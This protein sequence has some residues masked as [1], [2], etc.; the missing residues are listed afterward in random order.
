M[1][2][3]RV[4]A[5]IPLVLVV[6]FLVMSLTVFL[7]GDEAVTL[8]GENASQERVEEVRQE[9][10]LDRP[11]V[12]RYF[13]WLGNAVRGDLGTSLFTKRE[14]V[15]EIAT[16]WVVT[17]QLVIGS[18]L[19]A[20]AIGVPSGVIAGRHKGKLPDRAAT[21]FAS[22][23]V[24]IPSFVVG[25]WLIVIFAAWLGAVPF[26]GYVPFSQ[27][28]SG[29]ANRMILP[30]IALS[31]VMIAE[32]T[33]QIRAGLVDTLDTDFIRTARAKGLRERTV[34]NKHALRV[35]VSPALSVVSVNIARSF[36]GAV[37]IEEVF[38]LP[39]LGRMTVNAIIQ[40][41]LP[42]LQGVI[43]LAVLV[44]VVMTLL[45]DI[46]NMKLNPRLRFERS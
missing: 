8:A 12:E 27:S 46:A 11:L 19:V 45:A 44:A 13:K 21:L 25:L 1:I 32:L 29:W 23:G 10:D 3:R 15:S 9:L 26:A 42:V 2:W 39:G 14:V 28:P 38:A 34:V 17:L 37:V 30:T 4:L 33:R 36:G 16:R 35:A 43:P 20:L 40:R 7:P 22:V 24:A 41:D 6:S 31:G 18:L 5:I